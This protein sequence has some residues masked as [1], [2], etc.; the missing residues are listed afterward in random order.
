LLSED[1]DFNSRIGSTPKEDT[2]R[3]DDNGEDEFERKLTLFNMFN[4]P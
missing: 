1:E 2:D 3:D 4:M